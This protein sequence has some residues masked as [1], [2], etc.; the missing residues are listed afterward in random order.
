MCNLSF[1]FSI[2]YLSVVYLQVQVKVT[3]KVTN[4]KMSNA[5]LCRIWLKTPTTIISRN[6]SSARGVTS[7]KERHPNKEAKKNR[8]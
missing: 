7:N 5:G 1:L 4:L 6:D 3:L 2:V 8:Q